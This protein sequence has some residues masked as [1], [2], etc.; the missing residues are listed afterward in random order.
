MAESETERRERTGC[1]Q[2]PAGWA[3]FFSRFAWFSLVFLGCITV[4]YY[5][6]NPLCR[7]LSLWGQGIEGLSPND[8]GIWGQSELPS[9]Q[10]VLAFRSAGSKF[11]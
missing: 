8:Q 5:C 2:L 10:K 3:L 7:L 11:V 4:A 9:P 1:G 6:L